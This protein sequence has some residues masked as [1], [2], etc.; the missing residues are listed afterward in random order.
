M[1]EN[2]D[3]E[4]TLKV[5]LPNF[6]ESSYIADLVKR[7]MELELQLELENKQLIITINDHVGWSCDET[8]RGVAV[9]NIKRTDR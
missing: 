8:K 4:Q 3:V 1:I 2:I 9:I 5:G 6:W 7:W